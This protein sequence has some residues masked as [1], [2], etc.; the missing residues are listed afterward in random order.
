MELPNNQANA[1]IRSGQSHATGGKKKTQVSQVFISTLLARFG[2]KT[3]QFYHMMKQ[4]P[5]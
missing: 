2:T 5:N 1:T 4:S 3:L